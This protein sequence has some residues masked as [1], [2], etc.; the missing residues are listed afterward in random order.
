[1]N[2]LYENK[3]L[4]FYTNCQGGIGINKLL[5]NKIKFKTINYIQTFSTIWNNQE[6]PIDILNNADV[7]IYQPINN[8]YGKYST[9]T[10]I[11]DNILKYLKQDCIK[12]SFPYI[13]FSCLFPLYF[14][15]SAAQIDGGDSYDIS[16]IVNRDI[17]L[18]LKK[19][20]TNEEIILLY[21]SQEIDFNF[22]DNYENTIERIKDTEKNC[23]IIITNLFTL[24]NIKKQ[25]LMH[26]N[27]HP[28][29]YVLKYITNEVLK[30][31]QLPTFDFEEFNTEILSEL[32]Y[33]IYSYN[34]YKFD[35]LK[36]SDCN[37][38]IFKNM[39]Q[40]ILDEK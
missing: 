2:S 7:F 20:Y 1:M 19:K 3:N 9:D 24:D 35:W 11:E 18:E 32:S 17:I 5:S 33:S 26:T 39:L 8:K 40:Y 22:K 29:N 15:N 13:Y 25:K 31:L 30:I 14:A 27:N 38:T 4:V 34:Y 10:N 6:L 37:E 28:T 21:N 16:K 12:I 23:N 36:E